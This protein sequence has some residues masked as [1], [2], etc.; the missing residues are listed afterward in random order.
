MV[1]WQVGQGIRGKRECMPPSDSYLLVFLQFCPDECPRPERQVICWVL[2]LFLFPWNSFMKEFSAS[3]KV[4]KYK[5][6]QNN[7]VMWASLGAIRAVIQGPLFASYILTRKKR[8][9]PTSTMQVNDGKNCHSRFQTQIQYHL[10]QKASITYLN[11]WKIDPHI[12][13]ICVFF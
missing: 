2:F 3:L 11:N 6:L 13:E 10:F 8:S 5:S 7:L 9:F 4:K 12:P 1:K